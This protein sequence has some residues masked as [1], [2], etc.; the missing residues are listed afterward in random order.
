MI[1]FTRDEGYG[2]DKIC[3]GCLYVIYLVKLGKLKLH[4][5]ENAKCYKT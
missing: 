4:H 2:V 1:L 3:P 5:N